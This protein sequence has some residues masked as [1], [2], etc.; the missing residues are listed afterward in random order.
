MSY[1]VRDDNA[2]FG[3]A[4][5]V[6]LPNGAGAPTIANLQLFEAVVFSAQTAA[7]FAASTTY[8]IYLAPLAPGASTGI[9]PLGAQY[10]IAGATQFYST[11]AGSAATYTI[12]VC[13]S[14]TANGSG[15]TAATAPALN[16]ALTNAPANIT[17]STNLNN[18]VV[19]AGDRINL[20]V[21]A[22]ATT[23]LVDFCVS[24]YLIRVA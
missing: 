1:N 6:E 8:T 21:G 14:G 24:I 20:V 22:T 11:A 23:S 9:V 4:A 3:P 5:S 19:N 16:T 7:A 18:V 2:T 17:L 13:P 12:E 10:K 15:R